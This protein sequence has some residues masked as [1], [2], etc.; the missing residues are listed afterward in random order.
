L[1]KEEKKIYP[2]LGIDWF[3]RRVLGFGGWH[4]LHH[5]L[6]MRYSGL[7]DKKQT[8]EYPVGREIYAGDIVQFPINLNG[9]ETEVRDVVAI[10][11][12]NGWF[13]VISTDADPLCLHHDEC[14]VIGT[15]QEKPELLGAE[16]QKMLKLLKAYTFV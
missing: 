15:I 9:K 5:F 12:A 16:L 4:P 7:R 11:P 1:H 2:I 6:L 10:D 13:V 3:N 8:P 14:E